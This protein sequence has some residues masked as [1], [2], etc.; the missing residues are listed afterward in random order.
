V[1]LSKV[2]NTRGHFPCDEA[3][4]KL[5]YLALRN[6]TKK[7]QRPS[8]TWTAVQFAIQFGETIPYAGELKS[9]KVKTISKKVRN[10]NVGLRSAPAPMRDLSTIAFFW[11][12]A[13]MERSGRPRLTTS[14]VHNQAEIPLAN[15]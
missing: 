8:I 11:T 9:E 6:I 10:T 12:G 1:Q 13:I 15:H 7:W 5:I 4:T 2:L 14:H 3:A